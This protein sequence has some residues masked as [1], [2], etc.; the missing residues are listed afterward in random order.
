M[1]FTNSQIQ[2]K[3][4]LP[5]IL[6]FIYKKILQNFIYSVKFLALNTGIRHN[7]PFILQAVYAVV[8]SQD[9][10]YLPRIGVS[11]RYGHRLDT[12]CKHK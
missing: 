3:Q 2:D 6:H 10:S 5:L 7:A 4:L 9:A 8:R 11:I 1:T 12:V